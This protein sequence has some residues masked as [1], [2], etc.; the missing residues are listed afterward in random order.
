MKIIRKFPV[1]FLFAILVLNVLLASFLILV[2]SDGIVN[3]KFA[4]ILG[5]LVLVLLLGL[6]VYINVIYFRNGLQKQK[7]FSIIPFVLL[8]V[9]NLQVTIFSVLVWLDLFDGKTDALLP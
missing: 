3:Y 9:V 6:L 2:L 7:R 8:G 4:F 1:L 5:A